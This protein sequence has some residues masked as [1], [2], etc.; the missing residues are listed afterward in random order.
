MVSEKKFDTG[1]ILHLVGFRTYD[2]IAGVL[3][4][5]VGLRI[6]RLGFS[7]DI[8]QPVFDTAIGST[9]A[10][11]KSLFS[12]TQVT[13][14]FSFLAPGTT[15][16]GV[17]IEFNAAAPFWSP[18]EELGNGHI[19]SPPLEDVARFSWWLSRLPTGGNDRLGQL[20]LSQLRSGK[21]ILKNFSIHS[22]SGSICG[23][24]NGCLAE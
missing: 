3:P 22:I 16:A 12:E 7:K 15:S 9:P 13:P 21:A 17:V 23:G 19:P 6:L 5:S 24:G 2:H 1:V 20:A 10:T 4:V 11:V 18:F 8:H 14:A